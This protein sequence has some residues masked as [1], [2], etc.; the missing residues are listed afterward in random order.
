MAPATT[1][2]SA[3]SPASCPLVR[4]SPRW[5]AHRPLPSI[6]IATCPGTRSAGMLGGWAPLGCAKGRGYA[7]FTRSRVH[8]GVRVT[9]V[10]EAQGSHTTL[11]VPLEEGGRETTALTPVSTR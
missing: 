9:S 5:L 1:S 2:T 8:G 10:H 3:A 7:L 4:G 6:T 11:E